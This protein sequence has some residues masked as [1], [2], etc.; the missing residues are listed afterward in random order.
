VRHAACRAPRTKAIVSCVALASALAAQPAAGDGAKAPS[1]VEC[2]NANSDGQ[3]L[4]LDGKFAAARSEFE[5]CQSMGCPQIVR[6]DCAQRMDDL[7]HAQPT[8][9]FDVKDP[10]GADVSVTAVTVDGAQLSGRLAGGAL[11]V[12]PGEHDVVVNLAGRPPVTRHLVIKEGEKNRRDVVVLGP[13]LPPQQAPAVEPGA[14]NGLGTRKILA[15]T[16]GGAGIASV[17]LGS[18]F[19][20]LTLSA[21]SRQNSDCATTTACQRPSQ[22]VSDHSASVTDGAVS[23]VAF[24]AAGV[25]LG[26]GALLFF[27]AGASPTS[28][29]SV[30]LRLV[31]SVRPGGGGMAMEG[32]F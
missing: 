30:G 27:T 15:L 1:K 17:V 2:A 25:L 14:S 12:D 10:A 13:L 11:R 19:G 21:V 23:T 18:V 3:A 28:H 8:L 6:D 22:A 31:P 7:E 26:G 9:V 5:K 4:R 29:E 16:A 20:A 32:R 24:V